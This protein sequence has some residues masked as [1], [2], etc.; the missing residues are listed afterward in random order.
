MRTVGWCLALCL[1]AAVAPAHRVSAQIVATEAQCEEA[2]A[3]VE[4]TG[5]SARALKDFAKSYANCTQVDL[6]NVLMVGKTGPG[7]LG[8]GG[9]GWGPTSAAS[10]PVQRQPI[11]V[12]AAPH[13]RLT[14][15]NG[16]YALIL[17]R[18][19]QDGNDNAC[20]IFTRYLGFTPG[21]PIDGPVIVEGTA[22][23]QLPVYWP[24]SSDC[25]CAINRGLQTDA[26]KL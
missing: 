25:S 1:L 16:G 18:R 11:G 15:V 24:T 17:M 19:G 21:T 9:R 7:A 20:K 26:G 3:L 2:W 12:L 13:D 10:V 8:S 5:F 4:N 6:T 22:V 14:P 23:Y